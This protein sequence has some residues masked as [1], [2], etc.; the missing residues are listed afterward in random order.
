VSAPDDTPVTAA[1]M[2]RRIAAGR[3]ELDRAL[4]SYSGVTTD[5]WAPKDQM[6]HIACWERSGLALLNGEERLAH[7]GLERDAHETLGIDGV[8]DYIYAFYADMP[9]AEI[10][11]LYDQVHADLLTK[12]RSMSDED[13]L[14]PYSH[15][16]PDDPPYNERPVWP[17]IVG[18]T[19][20][21]YA[22]HIEYMKGAS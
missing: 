1:E 12:L 16:Q 15:Y 13:L 5:G 22:E 20:G 11:A 8:N 17:W 18:N 10:R 7:V 3:A 9:E 2:L 21:H 19:F 14:K 4:A 6:A